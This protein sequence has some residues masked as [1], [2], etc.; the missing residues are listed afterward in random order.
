MFNQHNS[1]PNKKN[2]MIATLDGMRWHEIKMA[3][4]LYKKELAATFAAL[5]NFNLLQAI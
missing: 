5:L 1:S 2:I 4:L 3:G